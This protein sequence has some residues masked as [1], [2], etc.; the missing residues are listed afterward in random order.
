MR[1]VLSLF[2]WEEGTMRRIVHTHH[3]REVPLPGYMYT[4]PPPRVH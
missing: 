3:G 4:I 1:R 2:L